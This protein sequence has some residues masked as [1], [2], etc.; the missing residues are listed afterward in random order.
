MQNLPFSPMP[1]PLFVIG[2]I[3][4]SIIGIL[5]PQIFSFAFGAK[6]CEAGEY[7]QI[8]APFFLLM[9]VVSPLTTA[10]IIAE[11]QE[12]ILVVQLL[13]L[14][15]CS[16]ALVAGGLMENVKLA[17]LLYSIGGSIRYLI[18]L[19]FCFKFSGNRLTN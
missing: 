18:E 10:L 17:I 2:I 4:L 14:V 15:L 12:L 7:V 9:F 6:W 13:Y 11:K 8:L 16:V 19:F 3:P 1:Y 5:G